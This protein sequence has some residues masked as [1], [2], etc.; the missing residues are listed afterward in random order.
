MSSLRHL[1][2]YW[3]LYLQEQLTSV[4]PSIASKS[5]LA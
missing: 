1:Q 3:T 4:E 5:T 2:I